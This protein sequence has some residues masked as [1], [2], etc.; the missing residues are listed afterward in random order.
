MQNRGM[1][2]FDNTRIDRWFPKLVYVA[3][4]VL[5]EKQLKH[6]GQSCKEAL[7]KYGACS[8]G[9]HAI[10]STHSTY[11]QLNLLDSFTEFNDIVLSYVKD[12]MGEMHYLPYVIDRMAIL[13]MWTNISNE[14][15]YLFP[16]QHPNSLIAGAFYVDA[17]KGAKISFYDDFKNFYLPQQ[18]NEL[19][20]TVAEY[21]CIPNNLLLFRS[22]LIHGTVKQPKGEKL[23][24]SFNTYMKE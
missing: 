12:F 24:V 11:D 4:N 15:D 14:G 20:Y 1:K 22:D 2:M 21:D 23:V 7:V 16:H 9:Y 13:N 6:V 17:P 5:T 10:Q 19:T 8:S 18:R 3:E